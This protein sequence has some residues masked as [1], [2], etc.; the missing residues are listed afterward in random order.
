MGK[1]ALVL[2]AALVGCAAGINPEVRYCGEDASL[3]GRCQTDKRGETIYNFVTYWGMYCR[4]TEVQGQPVWRG[5][6]PARCPAGYVEAASQVGP[7]GGNC[8]KGMTGKLCGCNDLLSCSLRAVGREAKDNCALTRPWV[9][10]KV[11]VC[12]RPGA[13]CLPG[14]EMRVNTEVY[15]NVI[16]SHDQSKMMSARHPS[17]AKGRAVY[18]G[19]T[20]YTW[21]WNTNTKGQLVFWQSDASKPYNQWR[22]VSAGG[23]R[24]H[25]VN[26]QTGRYLQSSSY[27]YSKGK[28][29]VA[30]LNGAGA[31]TPV[32]VEAKCNAQ[33]AV[34]LTTYS[35]GRYEGFKIGAHG[36]LAFTAMDYTEY[37]NTGCCS[38]GC[39]SGWRYISSSSSGCFPFCKFQKCSRPRVKTAENKRDRLFYLREVGK[40]EPSDV[41]G[42]TLDTGNNEVQDMAVS[43]AGAVVMGKVTS[44]KD[45]L[46]Y[47]NWAIDK[48]GKVV[49]KLLTTFPKTGAKLL[50]AA[51]MGLTA[52]NVGLS[53]VMSFVEESVEEKLAKLE[54]K[55]IK[56]VQVMLDD[57]LLKERVGQAR[58]GMEANRRIVMK[59]TATEKYTVFTLD[60]SVKDGDDKFR[61]DVDDIAEKLKLKADEHYTEMEK[62]IPK[63]MG[64]AKIPVSTL[65]IKASRY[66]FNTYLLGAMEWVTMVQDSIYMNAYL[67]TAYTC[68]QLRDNNNLVSYLEE[69]KTNAHKMQQLLVDTRLAKVTVRSR[70]KFAGW[71]AKDSHFDGT[72][73]IIAHTG[74]DSNRAHA[75]EA[76]NVLRAE[77]RWDLEHTTYRIAEFEEAMSGVVSRTME[78]CRKLRPDGSAEN[79]AVRAEFKEQALAYKP[80]FK[81]S[82]PM[83]CS[84]NGC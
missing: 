73:P 26:R 15:Y 55:I 72:Y 36:G 69:F 23:G 11:R 50:R 28:D 41:R 14:G 52:L 60:R 66:A 39:P 9:W 59:D 24:Y 77:L 62:I 83:L 46:V 12:V 82:N 6:M 81:N 65:N 33:G 25:M 31:A 19:T 16:L 57:A 75:A 30:K 45:E 68:E 84:A 27:D 64:D 20:G 38:N 56:E 61:E 18:K 78:E 8:A 53:V 4:S 22:F 47:G 70:G 74:S 49:N 40:Y 42:A 10:Q 51:S 32:I 1:A 7:K 34:K 63:N 79:N 35:S 67:T 17:A 48:K 3:N 2:V 43:L 5:I 71:E 80:D 21:Y 58:A 37:H 13:A 29:W 54:A 76:A 44:L